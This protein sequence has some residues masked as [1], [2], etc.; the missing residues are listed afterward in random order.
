M[1]KITTTL[2]RCMLREVQSFGA[3]GIT[4]QEPL[5]VLA[6]RFQMLPGGTSALDTRGTQVLH[7]LFPMCEHQL[8]ASTPAHATLS[9]I[10]ASHIVRSEFRRCVEAHGS[11]DP[12]Q[13]GKDIDG[14]FA[15]L[16]TIAM[17]RARSDCQTVTD[18][19]GLEVHLL[20]TCFP[21]DAPAPDHEFLYRLR[22]ANRSDRKV[23]LTGRHW[24]FTSTKGQA[25][26]VPRHSPGVVGQRPLL[27]PG[28]CFEYC[29]GVRLDS[30]S[31]SMLGS[32]QMCTTD[33]E[34]FDA[35]I[36]PT[37]L[38]GEDRGAVGLF[39][40]L[41]AGEDLRAEVDAEDTADF[42]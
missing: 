29:S 34:G 35:S 23:Q 17:L 31:G 30:P 28:D 7:L 24:K 11:K 22:I 15:A 18:T 36:A 33:G 1:N 39:K 42:S 6:A 16:K 20:T 25:I 26:E 2:Y 41:L 3:A 12:D 8:P 4:L 32:F 37:A 27:S 13:I 21:V 9:V 14:G 5:D 38:R 40:H 10:E 19:D